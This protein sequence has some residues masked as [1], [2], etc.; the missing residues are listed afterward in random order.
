MQTITNKI[1]KDLSYYCVNLQTI[2]LGPVIQ[3]KD[4][5]D[6]DFVIR[7]YENAYLLK[8]NKIKDKPLSLKYF[9]LYYKTRK[10]L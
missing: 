9:Q 8:P 6:T 10:P 3:N 5:P 1:L 2:K 4:K 7:Q